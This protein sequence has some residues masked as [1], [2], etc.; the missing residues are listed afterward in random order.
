MSPTIWYLMLS[1]GG[2]GATGPDGATGAR[3]LTHK[4]VWSA[5]MYVIFFNNL[6]NISIFIFN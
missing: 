3:G 5:I 1:D 6:I 2:T 4:G